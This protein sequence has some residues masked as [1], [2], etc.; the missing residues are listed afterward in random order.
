MS[1][2][3]GNITTLA[4]NQDRNLTLQEITWCMLR[5]QTKAIRENHL[6][7]LRLLHNAARRGD[8]WATDIEASMGIKR[9]AVPV[10]WDIAVMNVTNRNKFVSSSVD[11]GMSIQEACVQMASYTVA[12]T[13]DLVS[14]A[15]RLY[16]RSAQDRTPGLTPSKLKAKFKNIGLASISTAKLLK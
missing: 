10:P 3:A 6:S 12:P 1:G 5:G 11:Y 14:C 16:R 9:P 7:N 2:K 15:K 4:L 13:S 8:L